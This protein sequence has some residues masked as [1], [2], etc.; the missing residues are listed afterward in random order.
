MK[1]AY[2]NDTYSRVLN[3]ASLTEKDSYWFKFPTKNMETLNDLEITHFSFYENW[4]PYR[5]Y[6]VAKEFCGLEENE[7]GAIATFTNFAQNDQY[8]A[9]LHYYLMY[10]KF[11]FGR[12]TQDAG[13]EIRR[14]A[15]TRDQAINLVKM[16]DGLSPKEFY[17]IYS[18]YYKISV[19]EFETYID[20]FTNKKLFKK[21]NE[22]WVPK[23]EIG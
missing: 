13:I 17:E 20:K 8:L 23:F 5:N 9:S 4:D 18:D 21:T 2:L 19:Q 7:E 16:Y 1:K 6:L 12:A 3:E 15:M 11:G 10:L 22:G 14:G